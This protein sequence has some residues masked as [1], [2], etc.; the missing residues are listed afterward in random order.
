MICIG[1][2]GKRFVF[3]NVENFE[4]NRR[5]YRDLLFLI[6]KSFLEN[7]SGVI[8]FYEIFY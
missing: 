1:F 7:I 6:D 3:I 2:I 8:M 4:E 5:R